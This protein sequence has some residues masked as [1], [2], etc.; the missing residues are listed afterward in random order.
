MNGVR[1][2]RQLPWLFI[3]QMPGAVKRK[4]ILMKVEREFGSFRKVTAVIND[5]SDAAA[6]SLS[7]WQKCSPSSCVLMVALP[8]P[9]LQSLQPDDH[10]YW[11]T[12]WVEIRHPL[13]ISKVLI[14]VLFHVEFNPG[15]QN[16][17]VVILQYAVFPPKYFSA[18]PSLMQFGL[19]HC[20]HNKGSF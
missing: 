15:I 11:V 9:D 6:S 5:M 18:A 16:W 7:S 2:N 8:K 1:E 17:T 13:P 4:Q 20:C 3:F 12:K 14:Q 19:P 10:I